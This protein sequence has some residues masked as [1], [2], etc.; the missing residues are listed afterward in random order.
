MEAPVGDRGFTLVELLIVIVILGVLATVTVFAVRGI[1]DQGEAS[2]CAGDLR[3]L[4]TAEESHAAL[5]AGAYADE[6]GLVAAGAIVTPSPLYDVM[7]DFDGSYQVAPAAGSTCTGT[8]SGSGGSP[9]PPPGPV[10]PTNISFGT[11]PAWQYGANGNDEVVVLGRAEGE[12][13]F[14][15]TI[16]DMPPTTRRVTFINLD[17]IADDGDIDYIMNRSR[18]NGVTDWAIYPDD[19]TTTI[20]NGG[21]GTWPSVDAYMATVVAGDPYHQLDA[22]GFDLTDLLGI[23][24]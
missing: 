1:T 17:L 13:D 12:Y 9:L 6:A 2:A 5:N 8:A 16:N 10:T 20:G 4:T 22:T 14:L 19:D 18:T 11:L 21:G 3:I 15:V 23:T 7:L 24:G